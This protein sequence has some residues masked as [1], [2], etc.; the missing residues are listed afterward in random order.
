MQLGEHRRGS[1]GT[2]AWRSWHR[3]VHS[4]DAKREVYRNILRALRPGGVLV[5]ADATVVAD[6]ALAKALMKRWAAHLVEHGDTEEQD[7]ARFEQWAGEDRYFVIDEEVE[8]LK[9]AGFVAVDVRF[10]S[11]PSSVL[12]ARRA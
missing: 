12:V 8:M 3:R 1:R 4:A 5:N 2:R 7:Y 11:G 10:R 6:P 9:T